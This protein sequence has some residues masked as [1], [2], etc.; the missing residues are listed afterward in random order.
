MLRRGVAE[1]VGADAPPR[2]EPVEEHPVA[3]LEGQRT[4][5]R[6][7]ASL[8]SIPGIRMSRRHTS[9][10]SLLASVTASTPCDDHPPRWRMPH[11][12]RASL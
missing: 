12:L 7:G 4:Q 3:G 5:M 2:P 9:G 11:D 10:R 8:P 6:R 1:A